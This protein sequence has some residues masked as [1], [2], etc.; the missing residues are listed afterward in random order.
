MSQAKS[1]AS[2]LA[3]LR[4]AER[5]LEGSLAEL[6]SCAE[7]RA[8]ASSSARLSLARAIA[9]HELCAR[10]ADA[11]REE[12]LLLSA[13]EEASRLVRAAQGVASSIAKSFAAAENAIALCSDASEV[14]AAVRDALSQMLLSSR[15]GLESAWKGWLLSSEAASLW[16]SSRDAPSQ[17]SSPSKSEPVGL[18][19]VRAFLELTLQWDT[20][21]TEAEARGFCSVGMEGRDGS[22]LSC[23]R[24]GGL[25]L[26]EQ[27][28]SYARSQLQAACRLAAAATQSCDSQVGAY[29]PAFLPAIAEAVSAACKAIAPVVVVMGSLSPGGEESEAWADVARASFSCSPENFSFETCREE[30][31]EIIIS[32]T[33]CHAELKELQPTLASLR[34]FSLRLGS[35]FKKQLDGVLGLVAAGVNPAG[36]GVLSRLAEVSEG[37]SQ[38]ALSLHSDSKE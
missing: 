38:Y 4:Q 9:D 16:R 18:A 3:G 6:C 17:P 33:A 29:P 35:L 10:E 8:R 2:S 1:L 32:M 7:V 31:E 28:N 5:R 12:A 13:V 19:V 34:A 27:L 36:R 24:Q 26:L 22:S 23:A 20:M 37:F 14:S 11:E 15:E 25:W 30:V 21:W